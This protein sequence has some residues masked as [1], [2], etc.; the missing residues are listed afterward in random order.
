VELFTVVRLTQS[1]DGE[2]RDINVANRRFVQEED[3][4]D[5]NYVLS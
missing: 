3:N 5:T 1:E 2:P 4:K